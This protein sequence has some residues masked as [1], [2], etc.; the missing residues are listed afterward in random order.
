MRTFC[1]PLNPAVCY[2]P[3]TLPDNAVPIWT[4]MRARLIAWST[5][6]VKGDASVAFGTL[7]KARAI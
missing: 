5:R 1:S 7:A 4:P 2:K 6:A 3:T